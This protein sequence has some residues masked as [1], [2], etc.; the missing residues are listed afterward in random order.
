MF[1]D[2]KIRLIEQM[3]Q[4]DSIIV[5]WL[6][7]LTHAGKINDDGM[8]YLNPG[9]PFSLEMLSVIY[10]RNESLIQRALEVLKGFGMIDVSRGSGMCIINWEK[11]QNVEQLEAIREKNRERVRKH[12]ER[13]RLNECNVTS[14]ATETLRNALEENRIEKNNTPSKPRPLRSASRTY[15]DDCVEMEL[16]NQLLERINEWNPKYKVKNIQLWCDEFRKLHAL[17][18]HGMEDIKS[19]LRWAAEHEFWRSRV[20]SGGKFR[21]QFDTL[22][23]QMISDKKK[24]VPIRDKE[25]WSEKEKD[26]MLM[27]EWIAQGKNPSDLDGFYNWKKE[28][29][30]K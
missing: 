26:A 16:S 27:H 24:V 18:Q 17:D 23:A 13:K 7:M 20:L 10:G 4:G 19:T 25:V 30:Q 3:D 29:Q 6:K 28:K 11:H 15:A 8:I 22:Y 5:I 12:R 21:K 14:N 1:N 9:T 2:E